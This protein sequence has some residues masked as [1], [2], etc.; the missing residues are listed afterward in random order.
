MNKK[1]YENQLYDVKYVETI[2]EMIDASVEA[3]PDRVAY[4]YKDEH[5]EPFKTMTYAEFKAEQN[6]IGAALIERGFKGSKIAVIGENSHRWALSYYSV[7]CGVGVIVPI[8]RNLEPGEITNLLERADV[9]AIFASPKLAPTVVPLL[10]ELP[11][12]KQVIIMAAPNDEVDELITDNR[13]ITMSQLVAEGKELVAEGKQGYIDAQ[14]NA[15]DLSTILF[16]SG[17]TGLAKGVMLSHRNLSQNVFNMSKYVHI[18]EAGRVLDVLPMHHVYEMTCTVMT[19]FYQG[20]TVVICEGLKYIQKNFV[21]AECNIML[22][23]PLIFENIYRKIWTNAEKSGSTDKLRRAIGM[24]MKLD[25]RNNRA[26][27]K[28]LFK[29]VHGIFGESLHLLIAGGAAIDP[30]VI[31][32]FEAMGLPMMQ[33]YGMTENSPIIAVNQDRYGKAASVGKPMPGTE[34]RIIDKDSSGIGEVICKGPSVM[35]GYYKDAEN[36]AKTIKDGWL[37]TG[38]YGYFDEDGFLYITGRKKNVIVT[39]GGKN[40]FP[41]EVEYYLLLSDYICEVIVY[42]KPEEVKDDLICTAIMY[43]DYKALEEAGAENDED[44]YKLLKEAVE[45]A[46]SKMPPYKRVKRIEIREDDFIK[47]T[48]LKIK[49]FEKE[50]YEYQFDDRDFEKG[51]RF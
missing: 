31:A 3:F 34:V 8:D 30:N 22:G 36:T 43:P 41:E 11:L 32:E 2:K 18:P 40:I 51:R 24:S 46:N 13:L 23:V 45:E 35:M 7:V 26:V 29:A 47:T 16:T 19:S 49:R 42:G 20:A 1:K 5:K 48:T 9:E 44:K 4:M 12:V 38:D 10:D 50:N 37:Y 6:A 33:G 17:T 39:K 27:T 25:L 21:E 28:R 15:D 14:I